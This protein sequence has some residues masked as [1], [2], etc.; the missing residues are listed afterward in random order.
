MQTWVVVHHFM[1][2][3]REPSEFSVPKIKK[4]H[5]R[6]VSVLVCGCIS[7]H[8]TGDIHMCEVTINVGIYTDL[9]CH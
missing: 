5:P 9:C 1:P 6:P 3:M 2:N 7:A 8:D 4:G